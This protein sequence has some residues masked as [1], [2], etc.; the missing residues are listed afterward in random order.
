MGSG[1]S[2]SR[3]TGASGLRAKFGLS[4]RKEASA[5]QGQRD[6][7][8][9]DRQ[10]A[11]RKLRVADPTNEPAK[12]VNEVVLPGSSA[13]LSRVEASMPEVV[14]KRGTQTKRSFPKHK[15]HLG[16]NRSSLDLDP[17]LAG[18]GRSQDGAG[19][20]DKLLG[21]LS[22]AKSGDSTIATTLKSIFCHCS[23]A[24]QHQACE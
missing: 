14:S 19:E 6:L 18:P 5:A 8:S 4:S 20:A 10:R 12:D 7:A 21:P 13:S 17:V 1:I 22:L 16:S 15:A 23:M 9:D 2:T 24:A 11:E 3:K